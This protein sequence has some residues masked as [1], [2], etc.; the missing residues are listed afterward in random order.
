MEMNQALGRCPRLTSLSDTEQWVL[1][2]AGTIEIAVLARVNHK[3]QCLRT[4]IEHSESS[5]GDN[6]LLNQILELSGAL[7]DEDDEDSDL[8]HEVFEEHEREKE[9]QDEN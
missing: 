4:V 5:D 7:V 9:Q 2:Y 8:G 3:T 1:L 6:K